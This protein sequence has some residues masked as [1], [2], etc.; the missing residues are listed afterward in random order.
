MK[1]RKNNDALFLSVF[2]GLVTLLP[3]IFLELINKK[4]F[5]E[6]LPI[7]LY[8]FAWVVL[9]IFIFILLPIIEAVKLRK[10]IFEKPIE[11]TLRLFGLLLLASILVGLLVDQWPCLMG[12]PNCD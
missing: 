9:T 6:G 12:V 5:N 2:F 10:S 11:L 8:S 1:K 3:F 7:Q 4:K